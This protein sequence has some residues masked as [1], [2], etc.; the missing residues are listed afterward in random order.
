LAAGIFLLGGGVWILMFLCPW[1]NPVTTEKKMRFEE[2]LAELR[3]LNPGFTGEPRPPYRE[4]GLLVLKLSGEEKLRTIAPLRHLHPPVT[5]LDLD[6]TRVADLSPLKEM[7]SLVDLNCNATL[8]EDLSPLRD[9]RLTKLWLNGTMV[10]TLEPLRHMRLTSLDCFGT[11]VSDL[12][13][14]GNMPLTYLN[15]GETGVKDLTPLRGK[16]L[17]WLGCNPALARAPESAF[18]KEMKTLE[19]INEIEAATFWQQGEP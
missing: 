14:L 13:P 2:V 9:L 6:G 12:S 3:R 10:K 19:K 1:C 5:S 16:R 18:L 11:Q 15:C 4:G 17:E 7:G 8:V